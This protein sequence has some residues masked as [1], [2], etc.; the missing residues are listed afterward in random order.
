MDQ[1]VW[2]RSGAEAA[3][4]HGMRTTTASFWGGGVQSLGEG[5][6]LLGRGALGEGGFRRRAHVTRAVYALVWAGRGRVEGQSGPTGGRADPWCPLRRPFAHIRRPSVVS[7]LEGGQQGQGGRT[8]CHDEGEQAP[9]PLSGGMCVLFSFAA[10][11]V[12]GP[13]RGTLPWGCS[14][15]QKIK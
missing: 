13:A 5:C 4:R 14:R 15:R 8:G 12:R 2:M 11:A 3:A 10:H 6:S 1:R 9:A 7:V